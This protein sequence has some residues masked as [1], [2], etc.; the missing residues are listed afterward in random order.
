MSSRAT[1]TVHWSVLDGLSVRVEWWIDQSPSLPTQY[2][3]PFSTEFTTETIWNETELNFTAIPYRLPFPEQND[4]FF[5]M[6]GPNIAASSFNASN[7][8]DGSTTVEPDVGM[9]NATVKLRIKAPA[10]EY[11]Y[12]YNEI[13]YQLPPSYNYDYGSLAGS[14]NNGSVF[15]RSVIPPIIS[16]IAPISPYAYSLFGNQFQSPLK[17][18]PM[19]GFLGSTKSDN[20]SHVLGIGSPYSLI[21]PRLRSPP[22]MPTV[23][24]KSSSTLPTKSFRT[25][26]AD[27]A[28]V[29]SAKK[30]TLTTRRTKKTTSTRTT[31]S[32]RFRAVAQQ[33][34]QAQ[35]IHS[36]PPTTQ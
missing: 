3:E 16:H 8:T 10:S 11:Q 32:K 19:N 12:S 1:V 15:N 30:R 24:T 31:S 4:L 20:K 28:T 13:D 7:D 23:K 36:K 33:S 6:P 26:M 34:A 17:A 35:S 21:Q 5:G 22:V 9:Q 18:S 14:S 25:K 27:K 29:A 2:E